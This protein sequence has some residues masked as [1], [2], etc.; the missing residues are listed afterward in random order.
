METNEKKWI[1]DYLEEDKIVRGKNLEALSWEE[2]KEVARQAVAAMREH[3]TNKLLIEHCGKVKLSILEIDDLPSF[4]K[5]LHTR[6][7]D[8]VAVFYEKNSAYSS[9]LTFLK[10]VV[11]L[12][13]HKLQL[14]TDKAKAVAWL[15]SNS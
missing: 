2:T 10:N 8:R 6:E 5:G 4:I 11:I 12:K 9:L 1:I 3:N 7:E 15:K 13:S 14:F